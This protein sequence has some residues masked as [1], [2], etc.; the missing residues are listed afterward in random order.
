VSER[1]ESEDGSEDSLLRI[2]NLTKRYRSIVAVRDVSLE[3][4]AGEFVGLIGPNG[5][6][7]STLMGCVAATLAAD[8]GSIRVG[9]VDV[10]E[11][12]V[13]TRRRVAFVSQEL[14]L[15]EYLTGREFLEF[16][17]ELRRR[18]SEPS[19]RRIEQLLDLTELSDARNRLVREY[20]GGMR[21]KLAV[22]S[23]LLG[24]PDLLLLDESFVG[25]DPESSY[26]IRSE[27]DSFREDGGAILLSSHS[28]ELIR[29]M[30]SRVLI[31]VDGRLRRDLSAADLEEMFDSG[32][33]SNLTEI[34]LD[35]TG[36]SR[37][38]R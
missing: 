14:E 25:L 5:A 26:R 27:L 11:S 21:R 24:P 37:A 3:L 19:D 29:E 28:L 32:E 38:D 31:L 22:A 9:S 12:P 2:Q 1:P 20:S 10:A 17:G 16:V 36:K 15:Y 33:Y 6:G 4:D 30:C 8:G 23:A 35:V 18:D 34:Y 7:K 13:E